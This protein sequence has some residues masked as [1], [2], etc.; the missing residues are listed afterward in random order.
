MT[1]ALLPPAGR[2]ERPYR[3]P[4]RRD[5]LYREVLRCRDRLA[6]RLTARVGSDGLLRAPCESRVLES[7][8]ALWLLT[9]EQ[10]APKAVGRLTRYLRDT[11]AGRPPDALQSALG[12]A[13]LGLAVPG[14]V[15]AA[16]LDSIDHFTADRKRLMFRTLL[17]ELGAA[18]FPP[19]RPDA[20]EVPGQQSWLQPEMTALKVLAAYGTGAPGLVTARDWALLAPAARPGPA[21]ECNNLARLLGLLALRKHPGHR[22][23]VRRVLGDVQAALGADGGMPFITGLGLFATATAGLALVRSGYAG[24]LVDSMAEA[25]AARQNVDGGFG[26]HPGVA[27]SDVDDT[28]YG[29]EFLRGAGAAR[30]RRVIGA[31]EC[32][33]LARQ[34]PDGGFPTYA[35]DVPSEIAM[36]AGAV[37]ALAADPA[38][39]R[40]V[41]R[42]MRFIAA[43]QRPDGSFERGW[44]RNTS[45][46]V[47]R[48]SLACDAVRGNRAARAGTG[49]AGRL[50]WRTDLGAIR[51]R[52]VGHLAE[53][54]NEDGGWGHR[55]GDPSDPISTAYAAIALGGSREHRPMLRRA[56]ELLVNCQRSDGGYLSRPDQAGPRPLLYD[57][58]ALADASVL[59]GLAHATAAPPDGDRRTVTGAR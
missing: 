14:E 51:R 44:S 50:T 4:L 34:N 6:R 27:Q 22:P 58:P 56:V 10:A 24:P 32:Y 46:A 29:I 26:F 20:Y 42:G 53:V 1:S 49:P 16:L 40:V 36:T 55:P 3:D 43:G 25:L 57:V 38:H 35:R 52:A 47:F 9:E 2:I 19:V 30:H 31:A 45:N 37:N 8:L 15:P 21:W 54:R 23:A 12:R 33:L 11:L 18:E 48:V 5:P 17:A 13:A 28:S 7:A 41:E 39:A 59:L